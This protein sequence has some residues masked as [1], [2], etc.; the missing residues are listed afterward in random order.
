MGND[1]SRTYDYDAFGNLESLGN[2]DLPEDSTTNRLSGA[3]TYDGAGN[4]TSWNFTD[5]EYDALG[6]VTKRSAPGYDPY[7]FLYTA[8]DERLWTFSPGKPSRWTLRDLEGRVLRD[9]RSDAAGWSVARDYIY[10]DGGL[11]A[12]VEGGTTYHYHPDH[13]GTP[14]LITD[15]NGD[16]VA[17]HAYY[18][19]GQEATA[20][21]QDSERMKFTGH[22]RDFYEA[23]PADD[24]DYMH[25]RYYGPLTGRLLSVDKHR[26]NPKRPQ[27]LNRYAYVS[28][29][30][31]RKTDP[32]GLAELEFTIKTFIPGSSVTALG[33]TFAGDGRGFS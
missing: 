5:F 14:R 22:E 25:A 6:M 31:L 23:S 18:P 24:L 26:G 30:P 2:V 27:T 21:D 11:L 28:G 13:L 3:S 10:S 32:N 15:Q 1:L 7:L 33:T 4:V 8:D 19:Y 9:Y 16:K 12:A 20:T 29:N 17:Y